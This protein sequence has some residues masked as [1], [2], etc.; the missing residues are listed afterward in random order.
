MTYKR[1]KTDYNEEE[2]F[3]YNT[4]LAGLQVTAVT[5][6]RNPP[7]E[8]R[9]LPRQVIELNEL[10]HLDRDRSDHVRSLRPYESP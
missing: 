1:L 3:C 9:A 6:L 8:P 5:Q 7:A 10:D 2:V 4:S